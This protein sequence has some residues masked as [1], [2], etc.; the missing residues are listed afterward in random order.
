MLIRILRL[1][2]T[3]TLTLVLLYRKEIKGNH[4]NLVDVFAWS[5]FNMPWL[6]KDILVHLLPL[7]PEGKLVK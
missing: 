7:W 6:N 5:Y 1:T 3:Q 2:F 4:D